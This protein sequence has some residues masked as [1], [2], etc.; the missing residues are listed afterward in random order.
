MIK[1]G[2]ATVATLAA[3]SIKASL[4]TEHKKSR[5]RIPVVHTTDLYHPPQDPD[6]QIDLATVLALEEFDLRGVVLDT[7]QRFLVGAP[8]GF[9]VPRDPGFIPV[10]QIGY[11]LNRS[12]PVAIGPTQPLAS[13]HDSAKDC[14]QNEQAGINLLL[15]ILENSS[16]PVLI[17]IVGSARI[18][19]AAFNRNPKLMRE[20]TRA[21]VI[22]AG[23]T[24]GQKTEWNV[25]LDLHAFVGLWQS[26]LPIHWYPCGTEKSAF[27]RSHERG[28]YWHATHRALFADLPEKLKA[29]FA[30]G[31]SGSTRSDFIK[32]LDE[33]NEGPEWDKVL[34]GERN[35][36]STSSLVMSAGRVLAQ[37]PNG[38]RF[39]P[40]ES[41][42][43]LTVWPWRMDPVSARVSDDGKV[44]WE[45]V[46]DPSPTRI[47]GR[48]PDAEYGQ[49]MAEALNAL[50]KNLPV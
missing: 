42:A 44:D 20:K 25:G 33:M 35:L 14:P 19:T 49:A 28:T 26:G 7:T 24:G 47:F 10:C 37:T 17:T 1:T 50:L 22:N 45:V 12:I 6:D 4:Q 31:F 13:P 46:K 39:L 34:E 43:G 5:T 27:V 18:V 30:Y 21:V 3:P 41:A 36:W 11:L 8:K 15:E 2:I 48:K 40:G 32:A 9:D 38:W 16:A 23:S 29:W